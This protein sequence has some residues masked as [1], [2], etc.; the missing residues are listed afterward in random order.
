MTSLVVSKT[1]NNNDGIIMLYTDS[2]YYPSETFG[3]GIGPI[4]MNFTN[5]TGSEPQL[6][7]RCDN[8]TLNNECSHDDDIGVRCK[9]GMMNQFTITVLCFMHDLAPCSDSQLKLIDYNHYDQFIEICS[10]Q[11]W[12]R[13]S[14]LHW[15]R[16]NTMVACQELGF[17]SMCYKE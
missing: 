17:R 10:N 3:R 4:L 13:L 11:R 14:I 2:T 15:S 9:P 1:N 7:G 12:E 16:P 6:W 5:C 8:V